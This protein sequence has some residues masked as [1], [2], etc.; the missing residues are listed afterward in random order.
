MKPVTGTPWGKAFVNQ[1]GCPG[2]KQVRD[3]RAVPSDELMFECEC[4]CVFKMNHTETHDTGMD[5]Y[6]P[7]IMNHA[8]TPDTYHAKQ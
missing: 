6:N 3:K 2:C 7:V 1:L 5:V 4:G 8:N